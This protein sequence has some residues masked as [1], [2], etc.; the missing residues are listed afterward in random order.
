MSGILWNGSLRMCF[1]VSWQ[2]I[3][4]MA[5]PANLTTTARTASKLCPRNWSQS[6][7]LIR[8]DL[9]GEAISGLLEPWPECRSVFPAH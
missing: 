4:N 1:N 5:S 8:Q 2:Q 9:I 6:P 7:N 3:V